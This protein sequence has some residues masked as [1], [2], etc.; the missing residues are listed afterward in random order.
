MA[1]ITSIEIV[2]NA[3]KSEVVTTVHTLPEQVRV[4]ERKRLPNGE[5]VVCESIATVTKR[6]FPAY[7]HH[8]V[9]VARHLASQARLELPTIPVTLYGA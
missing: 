4:N 5:S 9:N 3:A 2:C 1:T 8:P 7:V 6:T